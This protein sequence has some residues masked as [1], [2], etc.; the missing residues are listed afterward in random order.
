MKGKLNP[1]VPC[2]VVWKEADVACLRYSN[3]SRE[4]M[5]ENHETP[6]VSFRAGDQT[7]DH[8]N[9]KHEQ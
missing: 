2:S 1:R 3:H 4:R 9:T 8:V 5:A 6:V 7:G